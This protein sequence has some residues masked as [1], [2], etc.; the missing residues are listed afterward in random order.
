VLLPA[1]PTRTGRRRKVPPHLGLTTTGKKE[2]RQF[3]QV[4]NKAVQEG[5]YQADSQAKEVDAQTTPKHRKPD[6]STK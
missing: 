6:G 4:L 5:S 1:H 2:E 3:N